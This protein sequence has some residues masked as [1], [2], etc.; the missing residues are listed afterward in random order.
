MNAYTAQ[1]HAEFV[2]T[3]EEMK[4]ELLAEGE[5]SAVL[6][7]LNEKIEGDH[8]TASWIHAHL[9]AD[10]SEKWRYDDYFPFYHR[11][12]A[13]QRKGLIG[14]VYIRNNPYQDGLPTDEY[15]AL[16]RDAFAEVPSAT[17]AIVFWE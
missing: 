2:A 1:A 3:I 12:L 5:Q 9:Y 4:A 15:D 14:L 17:K 11:L 13:M 16:V 6:K 7:F 10:K 8:T